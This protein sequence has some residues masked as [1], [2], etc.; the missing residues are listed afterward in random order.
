MA[1]RFRDFFTKKKFRP[2]LIGGVVVLGAVILFFL[3]RGRGAPAGTATTTFVETGH[4][5]ALQAAQIE[6]GVQVAGIQ[7]GL[8]SQVFEAQAAQNIEEIR[9]AVASQE[10]DVSGQLAAR[11]LDLTAEIEGQ[12]IASER[13]LGLAQI[14]ADLERELI[15][16]QSTV[17][18]LQS[19][20]E[21][22]KFF[23]G[24]SAARDIRLAEIESEAAI[25][26]TTAH[27]D[28]VQAAIARA[29]PKHVA[30]IVG[31]QE[32]QGGFFSQFG[33]GLGRGLGQGIGGFLSD[34]REK[35]NIKSQSADEPTPWYNY[36][37]GADC[38]SGVMA[39][40]IEPIYMVPI[41]DTVGVD[42][43]AMAMGGDGAQF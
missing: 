2:W 8:Q 15:R 19:V 20:T 42:Y 9:A 34:L 10:L 28:I 36:T 26:Q 43:P 35:R 5:E 1:N 16:E 14:D 6:A 24:A 11:E 12:R 7:A 3:L 39:H 41:G 29:K 17:A 4:S 23:A 33:R 31:G 27:T 18:Q 13:E 21:A 22:Q 37:I 30:S 38:F 40:D 32:S 25:A